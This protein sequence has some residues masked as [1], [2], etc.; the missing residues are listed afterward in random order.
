MAKISRKSLANLRPAKN[1]KNPKYTRQT[2]TRWTPAHI[3]EFKTMVKQNTPTRVIG[4]KLQRSEASIRS[5]A[6]RE[7]LSLK[8]TNQVCVPTA[9]WR[10]RKIA[11]PSVKSKAGMMW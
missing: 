9:D 10:H 3:R 11:T 4:L 1:K 2:G 7:G 6:Q 5:K 8:P